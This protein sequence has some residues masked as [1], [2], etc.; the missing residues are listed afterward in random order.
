M[1]YSKRDAR[2]AA[3]GWLVFLWALVVI[4]GAV[5][6]IVSTVVMIWLALAGIHYLNTH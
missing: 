2:R 6:S 4:G 3:G 5:L 1:T